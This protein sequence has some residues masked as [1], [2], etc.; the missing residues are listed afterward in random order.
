M[1]VAAVQNVY[2]PSVQTQVASIKAL[3]TPN[4]DQAT[5]TRMLQLVEAD[6]SKV[7]ANP[8]LITTDVFG[9][10]ARVAH[11]YGLTAC[12]PLS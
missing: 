7:K 5:V 4:G 9:D 1:V 12:A 10:F 8:R 6:L 2:L 3:G 11:P